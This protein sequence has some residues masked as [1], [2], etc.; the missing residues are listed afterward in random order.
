MT[1]SRDSRKFA[2][3]TREGPIEKVKRLGKEAML[4]AYGPGN[5]ATCLWGPHGETPNL[6]AL[7]TSPVH[8]WLLAPRKKREPT[9]LPAA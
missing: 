7:D 9:G 5:L 4:A 1:N 8:G 2:A 6:A 3:A